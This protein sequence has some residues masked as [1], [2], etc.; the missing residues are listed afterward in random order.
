MKFGADYSTVVTCGLPRMQ[1]VMLKYCML[2]IIS[3]CKWDEGDKRL[4]KVIK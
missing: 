2:R 1:F 4:L 3:G